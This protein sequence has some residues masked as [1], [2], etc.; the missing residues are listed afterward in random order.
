MTLIAYYDLELCQMD[1]KTIVGKKFGLIQSLRETI[2]KI[3]LGK[4]KF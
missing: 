4:F 3:L 1:V 2:K